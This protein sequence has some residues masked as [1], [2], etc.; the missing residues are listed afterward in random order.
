MSPAESV[1]QISI[2][3]ESAAGISDALV[4]IAKGKPR[5]ENA[6][7]VY[8]WALEL[9]PGNVAALNGMGRCLLEARQWEDALTVFARAAE[10]D[11]SDPNIPIN[12]SLCCEQLERYGEA[13]DW[14]A[15]ALD[16]D[17]N[18]I[19]GYLQEFGLWT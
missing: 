3:P 16:R 1:D 18:C 17:P 10:I 19:A 6:F 9:N 4:V 7:R 15:E 11:T 12:A 14:A 8:S 2:P 13:Q 5:D